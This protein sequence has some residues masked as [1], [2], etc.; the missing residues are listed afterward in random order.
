MFVTNWK[1]CWKIYPIGNT[2][3]KNGERHVFPLG[4]DI[5]FFFLETLFS[6]IDQV[7]LGNEY[8]SWPIPRHLTYYNN[9]SKK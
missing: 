3:D 5:W 9:V 2:F 4:N 7:R 1:T 8:E 6:I